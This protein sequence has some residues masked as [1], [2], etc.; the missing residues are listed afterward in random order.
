MALELDEI[1]A[2]VQ[3]DAG[4]HLLMLTELRSGETVDFASVRAEL[5]A[6]L[7]QEQ[8]ALD[9]VKKVESLR[10]LVFNADGLADPAQ[11]LGLTVSHSEAIRRNQSEGLFANPSLLAAVF[12]NEVLTERYNSEVIELDPEHFLVLRVSSHTL[13][14]VKDLALVR[15][16]IENSIADEMARAN[17]RK[18]ADSLL[19]SLH[20][21]S[22]IEE[23]AL[24]SDYEWQVELGAKRDNR[25]LPATMLRR[26]FQLPPSEAS[27][28]EF[29]QNAEGDIEVFEMVR[30]IPARAGALDDQQRARLQGRLG[31][32]LGR[33]SDDYYQQELRSQADVVRS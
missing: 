17:I 33:R 1:S 13:P 31:E 15:A 22:S 30:V 11:E 7:Q 9:L 27:S 24:A 12:S 18:Q 29:V 28:F 8:A 32:E 21:G 10:D 23:L 6:R 26:L 20:S 19:Q 4:W 5:E 3:S 16:E 14:A 25:V 2:P